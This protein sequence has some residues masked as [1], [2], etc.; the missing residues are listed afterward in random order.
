MA[1]L[2]LIAG[3]AGAVLTLGLP[4]APAMA[5]EGQL[6]KNLLGMLGMAE[7][8]RDPI[9]YKA[10]APLVV[11]PASKLPEPKAGVEQRAANWPKDA[12]IARREAARA[13]WNT[14]ATQRERYNS[15]QRSTPE[16][17]ARGR[18]AGQQMTQPAPHSSGAR[19]GA[20]PQELM[21]EP[22]RAG[23]EAA[24]RRSAEEE[25]LLQSGVE[26]P[27]RY[28]TDPPT[29]LRR[30]TQTVKAEREAPAPITSKNSQL[31]FLRDPDN[32]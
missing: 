18:I 9:D 17:L 19:S 26:P 4:A 31:E 21:L 5:Q 23:R 30:A 10:R 25:A 12:D 6:F 14:P 2:R 28:L 13:E 20:S 22:I 24:A 8:E 3:L 11:P 16:E 7:A 15:H 32:N 1:R 27:R 29:G